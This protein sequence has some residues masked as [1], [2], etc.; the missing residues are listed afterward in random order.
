MPNVYQV[1]LPNEL[2]DLLYRFDLFFN[3]N[4]IAFVPLPCLGL[5]GFLQ[6]LAFTALAPIALYAVIVSVA[7]V[8]SV[9]RIAWLSPVRTRARRGGM[10]QTRGSLS[11]RAAVRNARPRG[12]R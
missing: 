10:S 9:L 6:E 5:R 8:R 1:E 11:E 7:M 4:F 2:R 12:E 3:V